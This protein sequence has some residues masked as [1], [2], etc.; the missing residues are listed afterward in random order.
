MKGVSTVRN[1]GAKPIK[2]TTRDMYKMKEGKGSSKG[3]ACL[4]VPTPKGK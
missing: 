3:T 2:G 4:K 1:G